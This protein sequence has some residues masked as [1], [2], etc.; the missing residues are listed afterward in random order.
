MGIPRLS[1]RDCAVCVPDLE[2]D[3]RCGAMPGGFH[4]DI[5]LLCGR[6]HIH[7]SVHQCRNDHRPDAGDRHTSAASELWRLQ[8]LDFHRDD[9]HIHCPLQAG[10]KIL[11]G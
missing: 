9:F 5:R 3:L 8:S 11:L 4:Q 1:C 10:E 7:A 2:A 6:L